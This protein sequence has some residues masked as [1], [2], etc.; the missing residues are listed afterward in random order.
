MNFID[1]FKQNK[2]INKNDNTGMVYIIGFT[3]SVFK[4]EL[5]TRS[6]F[7]IVTQREIDEMN[8]IKKNIALY[9]LDKDV[10][11]LKDLKIRYSQ[12]LRSKKGNGYFEFIGYKELVNKL[13]VKTNINNKIQFADIKDEKE[14]E[15]YLEKNLVKLNIQFLELFTNSLIICDEIHNVYNSLNIN[16]WGLCLRIIFKYHEKQKSLRVLLLSAT[17]I[18]NKPIEIISLLNLLNTD[19]YINKNE[20]FDKNNKIIPN[21]YNLIKK[22]INGKISYLKDMDLALYPSNEIKGDKIEGRMI[23]DKAIVSAVLSLFV[24]SLPLPPPPLVAL[25]LYLFVANGAFTRA[26]TCT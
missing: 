7:G 23:G 26:F 5:F 19:K 1:I 20:I 10:Q 8:Q 15:Y 17:P 21:G 25:F 9:N 14:L 6:E 3:K 18:N 12:R 24:F 4:K 2:N 11:F 16:N 22:S 13:I